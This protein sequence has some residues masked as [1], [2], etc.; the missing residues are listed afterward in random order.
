MSPTKCR[1]DEHVARFRERVSRSQV[2]NSDEVV[3]R[4]PRTNQ[5]WPFL[6]SMQRLISRSVLAVCPKYA[7]HVVGDERKKCERVVLYELG[8]SRNHA[9]KCENQLVGQGIVA[10]RPTKVSPTNTDESLASSIIFTFSLHK[11][12]TSRRFY[13]K[14]LRSDRPLVLVGQIANAASRPRGNS[15]KPAL[16]P[17]GPLLEP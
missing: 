11:K 9:L 4:L 15:R 14:T 5:T 16:P 12:R 7:S 8:G 2:W 1:C 6:K 3:G 17:G 10:S 13:L